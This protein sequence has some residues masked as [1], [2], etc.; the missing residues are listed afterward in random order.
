MRPL[1]W[2]NLP[3]CATITSAGLKKGRLR[4]RF[5]LPDRP[6]L[7]ILIVENRKGDQGGKDQICQKMPSQP[8][9][10][11]KPY[12]A[13]Q[14]PKG[15]RWGR[16][17]KMGR[18]TVVTGRTRF[19]AKF[20]CPGK[21]GISLYNRKFPHPIGAKARITPRSER[22]TARWISKVVAIGNAV[23][24]AL[25]ENNGS[26]NVKMPCAPMWKN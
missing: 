24:S 11:I 13:G 23:P 15:L 5:S 7:M 3:S 10:I 21:S 14:R 8:P 20:A 26:Q 17:A 12:A 25:A 19:E 9:A 22:R 2:Q 1:F 18:P 4:L 6:V 16:K